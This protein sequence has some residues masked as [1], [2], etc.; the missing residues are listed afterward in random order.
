MSEKKENSVN[1]FSYESKNWLLTLEW[2]CYKK[3]FAVNTI[4]HEQKLHELT[5]P[6]MSTSLLLCTFAFRFGQNENKRAI[7]RRKLIPDLGKAH[8]NFLARFLIKVH[9]SFVFALILL[10][11]VLMIFYVVFSKQRQAGPKSLILYCLFCYMLRKSCTF[12]SDT[13]S[14]ISQL[15]CYGR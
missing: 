14:L 11:F 9:S 10:N 12:L 1:G 15:W 8:I 13:R 5:I 7:E 6:F 2:I 3:R 4:T